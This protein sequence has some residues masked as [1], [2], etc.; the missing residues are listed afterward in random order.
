MAC[1]EARLAANRANALKST[2]PQTEA[3][4][5]ASRR[6]A[7]K[8]GLTGAG[9]V[10]PGE[11][12]QEVARRTAEFLAE[13]APDGLPTARLLA[14]RVAT[15]SVRL[16][17]SERH[18]E[19]ATAER[20]RV[21]LIEFDEARI[22]EADRLFDAIDEGTNREELL[23]MPE[24]VDLLDAALAGLRAVAER[25]AGDPTAWSREDSARLA[26]CLSAEA[27][28]HAEAVGRALDSGDLSGLDR[29]IVVTMDP[30][31]VRTLWASDQVI[32]LVDADREW[33]AETRAGLDREGIARARA[34][35][36][37]L[38]LVDDAP[39]TRRARRYEAATERAI[40]QALREIRRSRRPEPTP[41]PTATTPQAEPPYRM[42]AHLVREAEEMRKL[43][44]GLPPIGASAH[45][46]PLGSI[47]P[48][49]FDVP[50]LDDE[51]ID[52]EGEPAPRGR[53][54]FEDRRQR[55]RL[56]R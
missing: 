40:H 54:R 15:L 52:A 7:L 5:E 37:D 36:V 11:D 56:D 16:K 25:A 35:A 24:G 23:A 55:P 3:G 12:A 28:G 45:I 44:S 1:S 18:E 10:I 42:P 41:K 38:V 22:A 48:A 31:R 49:G 6:N 43:L 13:L 21:A 9:V 34:A 32:G 47:F 33:L 30:A 20:C 14:G 2:G 19:A 46:P 50:E 51:S 8:H 53:S 26:R 17:R 39:E 27:R 4:K 29:G